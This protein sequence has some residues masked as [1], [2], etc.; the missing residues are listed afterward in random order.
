[1]N[2]QS[3]ERQQLKRLKRRFVFDLDL[4][5]TSLENRILTLVKI[6]PPMTSSQI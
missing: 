6:I 1:M 2:I 3:Q 4:C 5:N